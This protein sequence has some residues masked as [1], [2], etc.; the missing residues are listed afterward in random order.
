M[1]YKMRRAV[2][3]G[4]C[5]NQHPFIL[6]EKKSV[7]HEADAS[8]CKPAAAALASLIFFAL[9]CHDPADCIAII[10]M[11]HPRVKHDELQKISDL[12]PQKEQ[13]KIPTS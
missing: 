2:R 10:C 1:K 13:T 6:Y 7:Y 9:S 4:R 8:I 12:E 5:T 3:K 11:Q